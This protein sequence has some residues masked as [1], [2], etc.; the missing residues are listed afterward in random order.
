MTA[1]HRLP[2]GFLTPE[3]K[4]FRSVEVDADKI[5]SDLEARRTPP[6]AGGL[7]VRRTLYRQGDEGRYIVH[8]MFE[9]RAGQVPLLA[10][11]QS[12][13]SFSELQGNYPELARSAAYAKGPALRPRSVQK[14][15][16]AE[17]RQSGPDDP[18][19]AFG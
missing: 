17:R 14:S 16:E 11:V 1:H 2:V 5:V 18:S 7:E 12:F 8:S 19:K 10:R 15:R 9:Q 3:G 13:G 4:A 6:S